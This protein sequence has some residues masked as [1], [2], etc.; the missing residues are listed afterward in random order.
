MDKK[1]KIILMVFALLVLGT[2]I[3][4]YYKFMVNKN[5]VILEGDEP[6]TPEE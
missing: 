3:V 5:F 6:P 2:T 4:C 1:S